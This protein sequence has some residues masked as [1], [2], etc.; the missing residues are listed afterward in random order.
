VL[1]VRIVEI[2]SEQQQVHAGAVR[3]AVVGDTDALVQAERRDRQRRFHEQLGQGA[4]AGGE[5][6]RAVLVAERQRAARAQVDRQVGVGEI[7]AAVGVIEFDL[8]RDVLEP[9]V[10]AGQPRP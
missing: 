8:V 3:E 1:S 5:T 9:G 2:L 7:A 10:Q 6:L 4:G